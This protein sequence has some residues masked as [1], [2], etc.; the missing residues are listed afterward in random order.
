[1]RQWQ[2]LRQENQG[3][4]LI[5]LLAAIVISTIVGAVI[6][7]VLWPSAERAISLI[8]YNAAERKVLLTN[9]LLNTELHKAHYV[10]VQYQQT[11]T[12]QV[13]LWLYDQNSTMVPAN[14]TG[15]IPWLYNTNTV[16][17]NDTGNSANQSLALVHPHRFGALVFT[18][19]PDGTYSVAFTTNVPETSPTACGTTMDFATL[20]QDANFYQ[21]GLQV[22]WDFPQFI[23][24][25]GFPFDASYQCKFVNSFIIRLST[26]YQTA[27]G[28]PATF[29]LT[30]GYHDAEQR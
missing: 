30:A 7:A 25:A 26:T 29:V 2:R 11:P 5:E 23:G 28:K 24:D 15:N 9:Q 8:G 14:A 16:V 17:S 22:T 21:S 19:L 27:G 20:Q 18:Q 6:L 4:T 10:Q 1:M 13:V 3:V 12:K